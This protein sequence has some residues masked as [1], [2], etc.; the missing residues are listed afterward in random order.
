MAGAGQVGTTL[1][2]HYNNQHFNATYRPASK[3]MTKRQTLLDL[4]A[5]P[6][7]A[8]FNSDRD[9]KRIA[10]LGSRVIWLAPPSQDN[11]SQRSI[12]KWVCYHLSGQTLSSAKPTFTYVSTTGVYG[13]AGGSWV[14]ERSA[15]NPSSERAI[16][17]VEAENQLRFAHKRLGIRVTIIRAPGIYSHS[18][19]P[20]AR[21]QQ[22]TPAIEASEDSYSNHI[23]EVD[24]ARLCHWC[25][26]KAP[27]WQ[28][29][30]ACD[31]ASLKMGDYFDLVAEHFGLAK[32][33][34]LKRQEIQAKVSPMMWSFMKES[35]RIESLGIKTL[36][37]KLRYPDVQTC[38]NEIKCNVV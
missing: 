25:Q 32:P 27:S 17:R 33:P 13:D 1:I 35:R 10:K 30:N 9:L 5:R 38:L 2:K 3:A 31:Q 15:V 19:L 18:R 34:R 29:V 28:I 7:K 24:L 8:D 37:F 36:R 11:L 4:G 26:F 6:I 14:N 21:I 23:H 16:R 12:L 20:I 22:G